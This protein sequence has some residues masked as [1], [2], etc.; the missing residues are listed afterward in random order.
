[1][2]EEHRAAVGLEEDHR[3][4]D[5]A[6]QDPVEVEA[7]TDVAGHAAQRVG[8]MQLVADLLGLAGRGDDRRDAARDV[9]EERRIEGRG[10]RAGARRR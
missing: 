3:V 5:E 8:A 10:I 1:V 7:A 9:A 6:R 4:L 2:A